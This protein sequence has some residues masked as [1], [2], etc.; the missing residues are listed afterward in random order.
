MDPSGSRVS[1][2][3]AR[4]QDVPDLERIEAVAFA[5]D[6]LSRR[7]LNRHVQSATADVLVA[8]ADRKTVGYA[9]LFYRRSTPLARLY[10][11]ATDPA[12]RGRGVARALLKAGERSARLRGCIGV[13]L[14]VRVDN[15]AAIR[16]YEQEG[17]RPFGR[18]ESYYEDGA[19]AL[20]FQ[21]PLAQPAGA[22][23]T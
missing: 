20:R 9:V 18:R 14:E 3:G 19:P 23:A 17:Y 21:K 11:I 13:R 10:S 6:R 16:L 15:A 4:L 5:T 8:T 7:S 2:R 1:V 12:A 22:R